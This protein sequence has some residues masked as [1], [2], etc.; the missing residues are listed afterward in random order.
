M[1][2]F[3]MILVRLT[4]TSVELPIC[5]QLVYIYIYIYICGGGGGRVCKPRLAGP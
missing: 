1:S 5:F 4:N 3:G 2:T